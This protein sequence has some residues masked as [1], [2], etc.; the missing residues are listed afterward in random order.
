MDKQYWDEQI[1]CND[2]WC[3]YWCCSIEA[4]DNDDREDSWG[5]WKQRL[6]LAGVSQTNLGHLDRATATFK[7]PWYYGRLLSTQYWRIKMQEEI[8]RF[9]LENFWDT[10]G[11]P[12]SQNTTN[13]LSF[14]TSRT[15]FP[16]Y[17]FVFSGSMEKIP[18]IAL[19][20]FRLNGANCLVLLG[21]QKKL[22]DQTTNQF[23]KL[24]I[25]KLV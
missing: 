17:S 6:L 23:L 19:F 15:S 21:T 24:R 18:F 10:T 22:Q 4:D 25:S 11:Q 8:T 1:Y 14:L 13:E 16:V 12:I 3:W 7:Y 9:A 20:F 5:E 2:G